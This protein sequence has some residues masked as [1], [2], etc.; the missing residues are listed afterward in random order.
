LTHFTEAVFFRLFRASFL[1]G[2]IASLEMASGSAAHWVVWRLMT[3]EP[4]L[5]FRSIP[6]V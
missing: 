5:R 3:L 4:W 6:S 2:L 1:E